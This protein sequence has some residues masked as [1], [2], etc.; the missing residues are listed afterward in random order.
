MTSEKSPTIEEYAELVARE[1]AGRSLAEL[2][3]LTP[4][5]IAIKPL[6]LPS[7]LEGSEFEP[8]LP[9][10]APFVRGPYASMYRGRPWTVRQYAGFSTVQESNEFYRRS[11]ASG[12]LGLSVAFDLA[13]HRGYDSDH[14]RVVGDV[15]KA[16][17]A[18][19]SVEDMKL[20]FDGIPLARTS[21]S[22]T[23]NGAV[24]PVLGAF[25]VAAEEQ[26]VDASRIS[27]TIQNDILKEFMVRN[28]YIYPPGESMRIVSDIIEYCSQH[29]PRFNSVSVSGYHM[30]EAGAPADLELG[31]TL[32][33]GLEYVR[34]AVERGLSVD[35]FAPRIS[36]FFA[37]G[38]QLY[39]EVAKLRAAR[40]LWS[41]LMKQH[42]A[43]QRVESLRL[44][45]HCQ[46]SG[47]SL[48]A[49]D[50]Y[51]NV[52]RTTVEAL[53]GVMGGTQ[54][55]HTNA[56]DEALALPSDAAARL[57]RN[58][59]L[60][61]RD[62]AGVTQTVDPWGGS[63]FMES[64][65]QEL[66]RRARG[67]IDEVLALGGM[68]AAVLQ[69]VPQ[70]HIQRAAAARQARL[71]RGLDILVGVNRYVSEDEAPVSLRTIDNHQVRQQ[72]IERLEQLRSSRDQQEVQA[73]LDELTRVAKTGRGNLLS[74]SIAAMRARATVGEVSLALERVFTRFQ[75]PQR[76][77]GGVYGS[78]FEDD[79]V[80]QRLRNEVRRFAEAHGR[81]PRMLVAKLGQD[82]HDRGAKVV[83]AGLSDLGFDVDLGPLFQTPSEVAR[84]AI[85]NDVHIVG[86][87]TQAGAHLTLVPELCERL[88]EQ[89]AS[90]IHV[91]C[92]G[93][94]PKPDHERLLT[95]G[96][97][98]VFDPGTRLAEI[99]EE[100]LTLLNAVNL[101]HG[102]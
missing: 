14:E 63:Y 54:S 81:Q 55:L 25:I 22:M 90:D 21:V 78:F 76:G 33:D 79:D 4:E 48:T 101:P 60:I 99:A 16:G 73:R 18:V 40:L 42:F 72:Q 91:V 30:H 62:E 89:G 43:P 95:A 100:L 87:S 35:S 37:I 3:T 66:A 69:G 2:E 24:L 86:I 93:I 7:D 102:H 31:Y 1:L 61:L 53:A 32:A 15:G 41:T 80:W 11:L 47:V 34:C 27:G 45:T 77:V 17:V 94:I 71:D 65:T 56:F 19:D 20:L 67:H 82:G 97:A 6:Y 83:A 52:V 96:V 70:T 92:G 46:T 59:Q 57:A 51:N 26:G 64:L 5:G 13:T 10:A 84:A 29:L 44:R 75:A 68:T 85:D 49:Q 23:M 8:S 36:F 58:T 98:R 74:A 9:G 88:A 12:Q 28:T 39:V 38:M 50:P